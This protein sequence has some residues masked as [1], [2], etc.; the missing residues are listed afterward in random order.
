M[1]LKKPTKARLSFKRLLRNWLILIASLGIAC[2][3]CAMLH[4]VAD[5]D[6]YVSLIFVLAVTVISLLTDGYFYGIIASVLSV[7]GTNYAFT[8]P[9]MKLNF[10]IYDYPITFITMLAVSLVISTLTTSAKESE[11]IRHEAQQAQLR[12]NLLRAVSHDLRTPL[13]SI[14]GSISTVMDE[15]EHLSLE[16]QRLLLGDAKADAEWLVRMVE[17]LLS[18]TRMSDKEQVCITRSPEL[19]EE[20]IGECCANFKKRNPDIALDIRIPQEPV[21]VSVDALLIEQVLMNILDNSVH[22]GEKVTT[23]G[24][25]VEV[26]GKT[27]V[28]SVSDDGVGID[29][30][31]LPD[32][33]KGQL[34][35]SDRNKFR[36]IGLAA[37]QAIVAAHGGTISAANRTE[38]GAVFSFTIPMEEEK[39]E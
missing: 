36:G 33:F 1:K 34:L 30:E 6:F 11:R 37:C 18:I 7:I 21:V 22:H 12:S 28:V 35:P 38:G 20:I 25:N 16:E 15:G 19:V 23:I 8:Y 27:A 3:V 29:S 10:S 13:T 2:L 32:L 26:V 31:I 39:E 4:K 24:I 9:Y 14:I 5:S 17:N